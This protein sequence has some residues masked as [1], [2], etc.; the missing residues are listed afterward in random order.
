MAPAAQKK[1]RDI[2]SDWMAKATQSAI[3]G[4][5]DG[6]SSINGRAMISSLSELEWGWIVMGA[7]SGWIISKAKQA[8][9]EGIGYNKAITDMPT[10]DPAPWES[11]AV[12]TILPSLGGLP[13]VDWTKPIGEWSKDQI[14]LFAWQIHRLVNVALMARDVGETDKIVQNIEKSVAEREL[15]AKNG[16][17]LLDRKEM[18]D[19]IPF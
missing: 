4:A 18:N 3:D 2:E 1:P 10:R 16:G 12:E 7:V 13:G 11:G 15:S 9:A 6:A 8:V 17:P 14:V 19:D 5:R